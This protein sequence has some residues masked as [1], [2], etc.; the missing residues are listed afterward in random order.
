MQDNPGN[1]NNKQ[2]IKNSVI[3]IDGTFRLKT[4]DMPMSTIKQDQLFVK[5]SGTFMGEATTIKGFLPWDGRHTDKPLWRLMSNMLNGN[6][7]V[8]TAYDITGTWKYL[9]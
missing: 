8:G 3:G 4:I 2:F 1:I 7:P 6:D 5:F 9:T